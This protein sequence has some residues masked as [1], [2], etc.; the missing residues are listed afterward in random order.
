M[1]PIVSVAIPAYNHAR[2]IAACLQS[3]VS[4]TYPNLELVIIDDGSSDGTVA[5]I[6]DF[7]NQHAN[8]FKRVIFE[9]QNNQGVSTTSNKAIALCTGEW[10]HLLGSDDVL[11]PNKIMRQ[12][13]AIQA[14]DEPSLAL[15]YTDADYIDE[16]NI[17]LA[18]I[19]KNRPQAGLSYSAY[20]QLFLQN[21]IT[22][23]TI[24]LKR[25]AFLAIGG[26]DSSLK[27]EDWDC[28]LRLSI[29]HSIA[30]VPEVLASYRYHPHNTSRN[31]H[32]MLEA[33]LQTFAKF[34]DAHHDLIP[35]KIKKQSFRDNL[36]RLYR[37]SRKNQPKLLL[38][39]LKD[40]L[41]SPF[42]TPSAQDYRY[43]AKQ[44]ANMT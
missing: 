14:W 2:Y 44:L 23:P 15:V 12:F 19:Q 37:W 10:V 18:K 13:Q 29:N 36:H 9:T 32:L 42:H 6:T 33:M 40:V 38:P 7:L 27:L 34:L 25:S 16:N 43:Y 5:V 41:A 31:Q 1:H 8:R 39:I 22:N 4:Q 35:T 17:A 3:V 28:W 24:A 20:R 26:F 30:R 21:P 11:Y